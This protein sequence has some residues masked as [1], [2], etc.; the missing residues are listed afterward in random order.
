M[1]PPGRWGPCHMPH[2]LPAQTARNHVLTVHCLG[3]LLALEGDGKD[4]AGGASRRA[5]WEEPT[6]VLGVSAPLTHVPPSVPCHLVGGGR[7]VLAHE[8]EASS[9]KGELGFIT[10]QPC[11]SC[12]TWGGYVTTF[13]ERLPF[14]GLWKRGNGSAHPKQL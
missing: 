10:K 8:V 14:S 11:S 12:V 1:S 7:K 9:C 13:H 4:A 2:T 5:L 6:L 3:N